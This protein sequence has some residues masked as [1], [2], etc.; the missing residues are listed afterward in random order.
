[1]NNTIEV[2]DL[3]TNKW[4][5]VSNIKLQ[6]FIYISAVPF[7][8]VGNQEKIIFFGTQQDLMMNSY[9]SK[10]KSNPTQAFIL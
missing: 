9:N 7:E 6:A 2:L 8:R 4:T 5:L 1:M 3:T 10:N